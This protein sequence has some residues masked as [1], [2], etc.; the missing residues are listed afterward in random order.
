MRRLFLASLLTLTSLISVTSFSSLADVSQTKAI[1]ETADLITPLLNGQQVPS[2]T[3]KTV[4]A[5]EVN[6]KDVMQNKKTVMFFY[7]GGWCPFCNRQMGQLKAI[8][9]Q[10]KDLGFQLIGI[11]TDSPED[12]KKSIR[13]KKLGYQLFS[14]FNSTVSQAFGLAFFS[15]Q[16]VT[17]RYTAKLHLANPL[18]KNAA[19]DKR[20]VLPAPAI[21]VI[22]DKGLVQ[23]SY[24]NPN[25][26][27]RLDEELLLLA[28]KLVK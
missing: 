10:L 4:T 16:E 7:R 21:Y 17:D 3:A 22:D 12:L 26:E 15:T 8:E 5:K 2:V 20:L 13:D 14:D 9:G 11:S 24:V 18:Q 19:G 28:A 23:F 25:Y 1:A 6:L 27:V